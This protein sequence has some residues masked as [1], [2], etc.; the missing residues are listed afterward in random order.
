[1]LII[2]NTGQVKQTHIIQVGVNRKKRNGVG[3]TCLRV[4]PMQEGVGALVSSYRK[5]RLDDPD[6][7]IE[8]ILSLNLR[9]RPVRDVIRAILHSTRRF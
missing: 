9:K 1:M 4:Y 5:A 7:V 8:N 6:A 3:N 2:L